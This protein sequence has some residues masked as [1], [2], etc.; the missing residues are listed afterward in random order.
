MA[1]VA[2]E[3]ASRGYRVLVLAS[4]RGYENPKIRYARR[5]HCGNVEIIRLPFSSFGKKSLIHR[6]LGQILFLL[7]VILRGIFTRRLSGMLVST[8]PPMAAFPALILGFLRRVPITYWLMDFNPDQLTVLGRATES[9]PAVLAMKWL[10][11]AIFARAAEIVVLDRFMAERVNSQYQVAGRLTVLAPWPHE[12]S[13]ESV[14]HGENPFQC[15]Y[16][17]DGRF[18]VMYSGNH[19]IASPITTL[20]QAAIRLANDRRFLFMFIGGGE[21]KR[22]VDEVVAKTNEYPNILSL[23]YQPLEKIKYSLSAAD[24]HV[25]TLGDNMPGIIHP[26]KIYGAMAV[27]RPVLFIGPHP[28]HASELVRR[29]RVGWQI[30]QG[31]V[32]GAVEALRRITSLPAAELSEMGQRARAA[33]REKYS[34]DRLCGALC[35]VVEA[36]MQRSTSSVTVPVE[37]S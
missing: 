20:L 22:E 11:R 26:C 34:K 2:T 30:E 7:Q 1:D 23:P 12:E 24:L 17:P 3:M 9:N 28:S 31:D 5:E 13:S 6:L 27:G 32:S 29:H 25:V 16:N 36:A 8:S 18:V 35:T 21:G 15:E 19:S 10:N 4:G 37:V 14:A 33:I